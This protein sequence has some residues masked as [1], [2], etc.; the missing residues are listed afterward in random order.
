MTDEAERLL[1]EEK[2]RFSKVLEPAAFAEIAFLRGRIAQD[3]HDFPSA[4]ETF[5]GIVRE[6][7]NRAEAW[8]RSIQCLASLNE[9]ESIHR[10]F[11]ETVRIENRKE[12]EW[13][14][15]LI[16]K[17]VAEGSAPEKPEHET[18]DEYSRQDSGNTLLAYALASALEKGGKAGE[19]FR[20]F[21]RIAKTEPGYSDIRG[22]AW[23]RAARL[24]PQ[25]LKEDFCRQ[26]LELIPNHNGARKILNE[27]ERTHEIFHN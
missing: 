2:R 26:C 5:K 8:Q 18:L 17:A 11:D 20:R 16:A 23:F 14:R 15:T 7:P 21:E 27:M 6:Y 4:V 25:E 24:A 13:V 9:M 10:L 1:D 19:A 12:A 3:R 22:A